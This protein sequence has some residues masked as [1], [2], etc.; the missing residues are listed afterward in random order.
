[1]GHCIHLLAGQC[2]G[3]APVKVLKSF[4]IWGLESM[5][6]ERKKEKEW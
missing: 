5:S 3:A 2:L 4:M 1:L 6:G